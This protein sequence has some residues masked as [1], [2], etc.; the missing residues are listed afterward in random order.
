MLNEKRVQEEIR[1]RSR[2]LRDLRARVRQYKSESRKL[3]NRWMGKGCLAI[4]FVILAA[5]HKGEPIYYGLLGAVAVLTLSWVLSFD[6]VTS[7]V[8]ALDLRS[9][10]LERL[11]RSM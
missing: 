10:D 5:H 8:E 7:K 1:S 6:S 2:K 9:R 4:C 3:Y 11:R